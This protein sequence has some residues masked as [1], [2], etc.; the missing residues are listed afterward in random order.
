MT[1]FDYCARFVVVSGVFET[2]ETLYKGLE[3]EMYY[4]RIKE[5]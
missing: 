3:M 4:T 5:P 1:V 2:Y